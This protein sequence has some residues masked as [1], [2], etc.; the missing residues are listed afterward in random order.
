MKALSQRQKL[1]LVG[2]PIVV[3]VLAGVALTGFLSAS[4][5][6]RGARE[7]SVSDLVLGGVIAFLWLFMAYKTLT[8]RRAS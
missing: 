4:L 2:L 7:S 8:A 3:L 6:L 1:A 5:L